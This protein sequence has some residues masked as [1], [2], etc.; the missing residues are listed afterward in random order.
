MSFELPIPVLETERLILRA[1]QESDLDAMAGFWASDRS[2]ILGG[3]V[4][5][6]EAWRKLAG[7]IGHW[8]MRGYGFFVLQEKSDG[9]PLG[10]VGIISPEGWSEPEIGWH[11]FE[12]AEGK[13]YAYEA[14]LKVRAYADEVLGIATPISH[15]AAENSRSI[16]LAKRLGATFEREAVV[17]GHPC[18]IYR[19]PRVEDLP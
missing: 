16:A 10:G 17:A 7:M 14:A 18:H 13:G 9:A 6:H 5:R 8:A 2:H 4:S 12:G 15:I 3:P 1:P 19:H 11:V